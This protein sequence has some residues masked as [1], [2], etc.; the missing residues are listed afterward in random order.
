MIEKFIIKNG[1][2]FHEN[3]SYLYFKLS[4]RHNF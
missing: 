1:I 4:D 3:T 2:E